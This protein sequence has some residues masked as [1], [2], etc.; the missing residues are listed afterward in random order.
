MPDPTAEASRT[1]LTRFASRL[2]FPQ[3]FALTATLFVLDLLI[4]DLIPFVDELLLGLATLLL[5]NWKRDQ[6]QPAAT[7][8]P[9]MK[10]V[11]PPKGDPPAP[12][13]GA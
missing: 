5:A 11:T 3:L 10:D 12:P 6:P 8:K 2:R 4:P 1:L 9:P 13:P 7:G